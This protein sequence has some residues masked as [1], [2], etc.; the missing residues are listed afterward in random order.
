MKPHLIMPMGGAG[1]RFKWVGYELPKPVMEI[2]GRPF[3]Y[4]AARSIE[5]YVDLEDMTFVVLRD[6]IDRFDLDRSIYRF[7]PDA[8]IIMIPGVTPGPV[9]TCLEGIKNIKDNSPVVFNDCDH[10]F[11]CTGLND[12]LNGKGN[13]VDGA[14][15]SFESQSPDFS[16]I[17]YDENNEIIGT[18]EKKVISNHAICGAYMFRN[19]EL[20]RSVSEEYLQNC[21]YKEAFL[22]G[23]YNIMCRHG[24]QI[25][26]FVLDFHVEFGTPQEFEMAKSSIYFN[27]LQN[28]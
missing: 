6:H 2:A 27:E 7:F 22:S 3:F 21:P 8:H 25:K 15:I 1:A 14:L 13:M 23:M 11:K 18:I 28:A 9:F 24:L 10:M 26:D 12:L 20:F 16:Y 5:K 17:K 19:A 4:W